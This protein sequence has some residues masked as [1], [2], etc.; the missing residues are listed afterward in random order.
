M[1][2][3]IANIRTNR[4]IKVKKNRRHNVC[5]FFDLVKWTKFGNWKAIELMDECLIMSLLIN[6]SFLLFIYKGIVVAVVLIA[7]W[8]SSWI[9]F[10]F[11]KQNSFMCI[12]NK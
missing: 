7:D 9:D 6:S 4:Q 11:M 8:L 5:F 12:R 10:V 1:V 3:I 2:S